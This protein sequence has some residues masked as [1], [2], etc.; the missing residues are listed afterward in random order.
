MRVNFTLVSCILEDS[1]GS[2][3]Y[4]TSAFRRKSFRIEVTGVFHKNTPA[5]ILFIAAATCRYVL[6]NLMH[7]QGITFCSIF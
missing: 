7:T 6:G 5:F 1:K 4:K 2:E 3:K